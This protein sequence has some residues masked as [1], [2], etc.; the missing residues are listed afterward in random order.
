MSSPHNS[1][2]LPESRVLIIS[3]G[4]TICMQEGPDGL[5]PSAGFLESAM[6][7]RPT[8]NDMSGQE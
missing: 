6:A 4:G 2:G 3:T 7:P 8:F 5:T 1:T